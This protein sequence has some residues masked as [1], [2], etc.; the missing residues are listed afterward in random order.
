LPHCALRGGAAAEVTW[1]ETYD[2]GHSK[3]TWGPAYATGA[4][5][6]DATYEQ[7]VP[8]K[9]SRRITQ[10]EPARGRNLGNGFD[11]VEL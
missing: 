10:R 4:V 7:P 3:N 5:V 1:N 6:A 11:D 9:Q 8:A 2:T